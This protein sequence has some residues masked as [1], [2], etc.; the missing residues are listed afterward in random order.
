MDISV[1]TLLSQGDMQEILLMQTEV[2]QK[3]AMLGDAGDAGPTNAP[4]RIQ[5]E[6]V[7]IQIPLWSPLPVR[8]REETM[9]VEIPPALPIRI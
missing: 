3:G 4:V 8:I 9:E 6:S 2:H 5:E 1:L 7:E